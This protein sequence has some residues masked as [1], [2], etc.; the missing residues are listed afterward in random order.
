MCA[1]EGV[2]IDERST[3]RAGT[4]GD[5]QAITHLEFDVYEPCS[6]GCAHHQALLEITG[7]SLEYI[8]RQLISLTTSER[9]LVF[10]VNTYAD[11]QIRMILGLIKSSLKTVSK[12]LGGWPPEGGGYEQVHIPCMTLVGR[13]PFCFG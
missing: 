8:N 3:T 11:M 7:Q 2:A 12:A 6:D 4:E 13:P 1:H 10:A 5:I 9:A